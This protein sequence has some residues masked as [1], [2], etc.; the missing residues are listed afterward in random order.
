MATVA[1]GFARVD[2]EPHSSDPRVRVLS[3]AVRFLLSAV[4][5]F[6]HDCTTMG[7]LPPTR[8]DAIETLTVVLREMP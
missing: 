5:V 8:T 6:R 7:A 2:G 4:S 3:P 1:A